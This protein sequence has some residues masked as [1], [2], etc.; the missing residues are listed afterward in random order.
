[1]STQTEPTEPPEERERK[2]SKL[3]RRNR[4]LVQ[5]VMVRHPLLTVEEAIEVA[6]V[7]RHVMSTQSQSTE[8]PK[9]R[10]RLLSQLR[11]E[12]RKLVEN[13]MADFPGLT[14]AKAIEI[15]TAFGGL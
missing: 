3:S 9:E 7:G 15:L 14:A 6:D 4:D 12:D 10:E 13:C 1:M 11:P 5:R 2:L 8:T